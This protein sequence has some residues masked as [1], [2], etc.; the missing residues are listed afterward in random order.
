MDS[1]FAN[2]F[3]LTEA[4]AIA[5]LDTPLDQL[6]KD[7]S[8][9]VAA[10]QLI[11][12]P[13]KNSI[14][15]LMRAIQNPDPS[16]DNRIVRR[17]A[18]E[19][20]GKLNA[21]QALPIIQSCLSG[22]DLYTVENA[23]WAIADIGTDDPAILEKIAELLNKPGQSYRVIIQALVKLNYQPALARIQGF[24]DHADDQLASAAIAAT[25]RFTNDA[26]L[27]P[28]V[29]ELLQN[30]TVF[31]RRLAGTAEAPRSTCSQVSDGMNASA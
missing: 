27:M 3:G 2:L 30:K 13:S 18:V 12:F 1:R 9:Y 29:V 28:R 5:L 4:Q 23:V 15:A 19:S 20:L 6:A 10:A 8:R 11:H 26:S 21:R 31:T 14:Q 16:L 7:D 22:D 25:C 24:V 17:K